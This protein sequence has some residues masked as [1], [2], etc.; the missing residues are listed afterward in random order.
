[1]IKKK[2][3]FKSTSKIKITLKEN[4]QMT[5]FKAKDYLKHLMKLPILEIFNKV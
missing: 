4:F 2:D 5:N 3:N 1:M